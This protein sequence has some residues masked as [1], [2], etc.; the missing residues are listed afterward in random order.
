MDNLRVGDSERDAATAALSEHYAA[1]R[2]TKE[3]FDERSDA[4]WSARTRHD[5]D[6]LFVDLPGTPAPA[7]VRRPQ[8]A[9]SR[10]R[11]VLVPVAVVLVVLTVITHLPL[12]LFGL[13]VWFCL[14]RFVWHGHRHH[15][16]RDF[17]RSR[18]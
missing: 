3:E 11:G 7:P 5:L 8:R 9:G 6:Q 17:T 1:G 4:A 14:S 12:I 2:L 10:W 16:A 15:P 13:F 18:W